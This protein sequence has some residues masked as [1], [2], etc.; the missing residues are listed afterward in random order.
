MWLI[1][2][3]VGEDALRWSDYLLAVPLSN[4]VAVIPLTP[5]GVG[6]RDATMAM[7]FAALGGGPDKIGTVPLLFT[8]VMVTRLMIVLWLRRTR[9]QTLPV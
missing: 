6:T 4:V 5:G 9:P 7:T 1:G 8:A 3:S 2:A